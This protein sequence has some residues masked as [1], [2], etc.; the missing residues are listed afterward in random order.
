M[1]LVV[2][3]IAEARA[4][5]ERLAGLRFTETAD[6]IEVVPADSSGFPVA[7]FVEPKGFA[8][9][10]GGWHE[11]F[12]SA[13]DAVNCFSYGLRGDC[14]LRV[15]SRGSTPYR[16]TLEHRKAGQWVADSTTGSLLFP[17]WRRRREALLRN[18][19]R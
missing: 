3:A 19:P 8:V 11:H 4:R 5:L 15:V 13:R 10:F 2:D 1:L 16:W 17:F 6:S 9:H 14:R 12:E 7:L 18:Q